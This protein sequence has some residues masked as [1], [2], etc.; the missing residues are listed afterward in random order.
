MQKF[1]LLLLLLEE[2]SVLFLF[3][4][5][6]VDVIDLGAN[7]TL[8]ANLIACVYVVVV[9]VFGTV[10]PLLFLLQDLFF[11]LSAHIEGRLMIG[12]CSNVRQ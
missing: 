7:S 1:F 12:C 11:S 8:A 5:L 2:S 10:I 3:L 9:F 6:D 4:L